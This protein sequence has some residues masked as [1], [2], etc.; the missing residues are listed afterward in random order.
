MTKVDALKNEEWNTWTRNFGWALKGYY[1]NENSKITS[2]ER[3]NKTMK[4]NK[5]I[6]IG[7]NNGDRY[8]GQFE[9]NKYCGRGKYFYH[10]GDYF[11]GYWLNDKKN[12]EGTYFYKNGDKTIGKYNNGKP[13]GTHIRYCRDGT[14]YQIKY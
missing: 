10:N 2:C 12:G 6:A 3:Y 13:C 9:K 14:Q 5:I 11:D 1:N 4:N 7:N 8:E